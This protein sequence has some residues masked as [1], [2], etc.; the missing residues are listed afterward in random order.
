MVLSFLA[1]AEKL[2]V[3]RLKK[4]IDIEEHKNVVL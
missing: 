2:A 1:P 4:S 3:T